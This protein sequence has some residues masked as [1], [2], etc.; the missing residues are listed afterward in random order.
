MHV[1]LRAQKEIVG[2]EAV[3]PLDAMRFISA[4]CSEGATLRTIISDKRS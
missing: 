2:L 1:P 3:G 4:A